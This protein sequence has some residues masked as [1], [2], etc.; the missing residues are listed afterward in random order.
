MPF[1]SYLIENFTYRYFLILLNN[2]ILII[3]G[4]P[5]NF[6]AYVY[7]D[8]IGLLLLYLLS[9]KSRKYENIN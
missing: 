9:N 5:E 6:I 2:S 4:T 7:Y 1:P 3:R 8:L